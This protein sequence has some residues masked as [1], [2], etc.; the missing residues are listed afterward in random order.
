M[1][2]KK[3]QINQVFVYILSI[4]IVLFVGFLVVKF[5]A[6]FTS[7]A[8]N[9]AGV[10]IFDELDRDYEDI[11]RTYSSEKVLDYKVPTNTKRLCFLD[12]VSCVINTLNN[13]ITESEVQDLSILAEAGDNIAIFDNDGITATEK[14]GTFNGCFCITPNNGYFKIVMENKKNEVY[15]FAN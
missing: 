13:T 7:D 4:M 9:R 14:I 11:Y 2:F 6:T 12:G 10:A 8:E 15:F 5:V 1:K 3:A